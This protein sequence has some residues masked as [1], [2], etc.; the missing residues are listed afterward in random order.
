[1]EEAQSASFV[2]SNSNT[3]DGAN[4][5]TEEE[6]EE[7]GKE[8]SNKMKPNAG[9]GCDLEKYQW[10]Q[11]LGELEVR[12]PFLALGFPLKVVFKKLNL[13]LYKIKNK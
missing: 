2:S 5:G 12:I 10:T 3:E 8:K 6:T 11:T 9:N 1:M 13:S 4:K 7:E